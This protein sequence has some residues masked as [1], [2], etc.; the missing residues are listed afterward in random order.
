MRESD[1]ETELPTR[2]LAVGSLKTPNLYL[3]C[4]QKDEGGKW[5]K[6]KYIAFIAGEKNFHSEPPRTRGEMPMIKTLR[7]PFESKDFTVD[8]KDLKILSISVPC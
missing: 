3:H 2:V 4:P 8:Q 6:G 7:S 1:E 5:P